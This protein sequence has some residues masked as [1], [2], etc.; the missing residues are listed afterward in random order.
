MFA[1]FPNKNDILSLKNCDKLKH[2]LHSINTSHLRSMDSSYSILQMEIVSDT[3]NLCGNGMKE[4]KLTARMKEKMSLYLQ[5]ITGI[6]EIYN[7]AFG[8][9]PFIDVMSVRYVSH[10]KYLTGPGK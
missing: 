8:K 7:N 10:V 6:I 4:K 3:H 1:F 9:V 5:I 2:Q